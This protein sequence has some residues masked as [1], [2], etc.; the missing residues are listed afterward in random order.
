MSDQPAGN[1]L[2][3]IDR[4]IA[5]GVDAEKLDR[6]LSLQE[7]WE[8]SRAVEAYNRAMNLCQQEM[9]AVVKDAENSHTKSAYARLETLVSATTPTYT[10]HGFSLSYDTADSPLPGHIRIVCD[11]LHSGGHKESKHLDL[12]L[13]GV[14]AKG[15]ASSMNGVQ[16]HGSTVSYGRRYLA[17]MIFN[18]AIA[19]ED[20]DAAA[21][22]L[23]INLEQAAE[24]EAAIERTGTDEAA[25]LNWAQCD[26]VSDLPIKKY[27]DAMALLRRKAGKKVAS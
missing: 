21:P 9:P 16:A 10:R 6:L 26:R 20:T 18:V 24:I 27:A 2:A 13:D 3:L 11:V 19:G 14:G 23:T 7:R 22:F 17:A 15:G 12:P 8:K 1:P 5:S 25:F 4:A